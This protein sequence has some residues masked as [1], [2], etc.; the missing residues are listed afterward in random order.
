MQQVPFKAFLPEE[1]EPGEPQASYSYALAEA[2]A[3]A[4]ATM[5]GHEV[6]AGA[7]CVLR[8]VIAH[9]CCCCCCCCCYV[10]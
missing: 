10:G 5:Q 4:R 7:Q 6:R 8:L 3:R 9:R 2:T 1:E